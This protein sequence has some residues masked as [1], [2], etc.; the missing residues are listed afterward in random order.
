MK[1]Q[2][3]K[4]TFCLARGLR[5]LSSPLSDPTA[6]SGNK[7][8]ANPTCACSSNFSMIVRPSFACSCCGGSGRYLCR[9]AKAPR[10]VQPELGSCLK[11]DRSG[12][13]SLGRGRGQ[14]E[15]DR[16]VERKSSVKNVQNRRGLA[17]PIWDGAPKMKILA[18][19]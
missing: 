19:F 15:E 18:G 8:P 1:N 5:L 3:S 9:E 14:T 6:S 2:N 12:V 11:Q 16:R 13:V 10:A 7:A 17:Y 4:I